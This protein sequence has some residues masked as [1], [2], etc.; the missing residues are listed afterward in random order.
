MTIKAMNDPRWA[1]LEDG[2]LS[3]WFLQDSDELVRGFHISAD[4]HV[5]DF[6]CGSGESSVFCARRGAYISFADISQTKL[7]R[8]AARLAQTPARGS[9]AILMHDN[10]IPLADASVTRVIAMDVLEH[11]REPMLLLRELVRVGA[12]GARYVISVPDARGEQFQRTFAPPTYFDEPNHIQVFDTAAFDELVCAAGLQV[13]QHTTHGFFWLMHF[14]LYWLTE[15]AQGREL[16]GEAMERIAPPYDPLLQQWAD[17][18]HRILK[19]PHGHL[20]KQAFDQS[21]PKGQCIIA[22]KPAG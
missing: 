15:R 5:L 16:E 3:G 19:L 11:T 14:S 21:L 4:D 2:V 18:W 22:S 10:I 12:P 8:V 9:N 1:G 20:L 7:D 13:E 6:G 17:L